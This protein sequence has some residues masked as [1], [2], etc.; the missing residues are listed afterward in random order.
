MK[1]DEVNFKVI[2]NLECPTPAEMTQLGIDAAPVTQA[3]I[4]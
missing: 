2:N 1:K 4:I 3:S